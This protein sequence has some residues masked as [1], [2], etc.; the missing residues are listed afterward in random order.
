MT[1][2]KDGAA[3]SGDA[4]FAMHCKIGGAD[5]FSGRTPCG[6]PRK[7]SR[8]ALLQGAQRQVGPRNRTV[9]KR[10]AGKFGGLLLLACGVF[11][12]VA[13][14]GCRS[15]DE[16]SFDA[17]SAYLDRG[18][19]YYRISDNE[20]L[21]RE[22]EA[23]FKK[24]QKMLLD[25]RSTEKFDCEQLMI[26]SSVV[27]LAVRLSG[28][29][30]CRWSGASSLR[31]PDALETTFRNRT[32]YLLPEKSTGVFWSV[33]GK[34][35]RPLFK[36]MS[37]LPS[38]TLFAGDFVLDLEPLG[39]MLEK[40]SFGGEKVDMSCRMLFK[41]GIREL[42]AGISGEWGF[43]V[44]PQKSSGMYHDFVL[45]LPDKGLRLFRRIS[46]FAGNLPGAKV[47]SS[48][49]SLRFRP[50][51]TPVLCTGADDRITIYSSVQAREHFCSSDSGL[52][53]QPDF[54]RLSRG[55][56]EEGVAVFYSAGTLPETKTVALPERFGGL[57]IDPADFDRPQLV[58][59]RRE[60]NG[61][62]VTSNSGFDIPTSDIISVFVA[63]A[64]LLASHWDELSPLLPRSRGIP[65]E[66]TTE[67]SGPQQ[68]RENELV[69]ECGA[70]LTRLS[71]ALK[72][73][74]EKHGEVPAETD[75]SGLR[76]L[77]AD[78]A[79]K[80]SDLV[81]PD[82]SENAAPAAEQLDFGSCSYIYF[83]AWKKDG[84][85]KLPLLIDRPENHRDRFHVVFKDGSLALFKLENCRSIRRMAGFL[86][87]KFSYSEEEFSEL[88]SRASRLDS[89]FEFH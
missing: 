72:K 22:A 47:D 36:E 60:S 64:L 58:V 20:S 85:P 88:I 11:C 30:E 35:N 25:A 67:K 51:K 87:T 46:D 19:S 15:Q 86:H 3:R 71:E 17:V 16:A 82:S 4:G 63:P 53:K 69:A 39:E 6:T 41:S 79:V 40:S 42:C 78:G 10:R 27:E 70:N 54:C 34:R 50:G 52:A 23:F 77:L 44:F 66:K 75:I 48:E 28:I 73:Y 33:P 7:N 56:P 62:S 8:F 55:L 43:A 21:Y 31:I 5:D 74:A 61:L 9:T 38:D 65:A 84:N 76:K 13:A 37:C 26:A 1:T 83:G 59:V 2:T 49:I 18:G 14:A 45:T 89:L 80:L 24:F 68:P 12:V 81:C 57:Q 32:F 29:T